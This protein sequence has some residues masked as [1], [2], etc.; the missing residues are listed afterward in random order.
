MMNRV[1]LISALSGFA[2]LVAG[3]SI[4]RQP[5][6]AKVNST[7]AER[8]LRALYDAHAWF[9][10]RRKLGGLNPLLYRGAVAAVFAQRDEAERLLRPVINNTPQSEEALQ[11]CEFLAHLYI[12]TG[13]YARLAADTQRRL[14]DFP[15]RPELQRDQ[16]AL[17]PLLAL[18][19][20]VTARTGFAVLK[21]DGGLFS[22]MSIN[23]KPAAYFFD[24]GAGVSAMSESEARRLGM[25]IQDDTGKMGTSTGQQTSFRTAVATELKWGAVELQ[26]VSF[27]VFRDDQEPWKDLPEGRRGLIGIPALLAVQRIRWSHDGMLEVG[28]SN[29]VTAAR[30][31]NLCFDDD[32]L[33]ATLSCQGRDVWTRLD[34]G[35]VDT[36]LWLKFAEA[37]PELLRTKGTKSFKEMHGI[38][39]AE[40]TEAI[41]L[42]NLSLALGGK[43][44]SL[45]PALV[46]LKQPGPKR[47]LGNVGMDLLKQ[48]PSFEIDFRTMTLELQS[49]R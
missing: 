8:E 49:R 19:D 38:G 46:L 48:A 39:H 42:P 9:D 47:C 12:Q 22:P 27:A 30:K 18:P 14:K 10:L 29:H 7:V 31:P 34:T 28:V 13:Q 4:S 43:E 5:E 41:S 44:V 32:Q 3:C 6:P 11:A 15:E 1:L 16:A 26:N 35:A 45:R 37:F 36:E 24:T 20:Q 33:I 23:G 2:C 40:K 21:H 17:R 25:T